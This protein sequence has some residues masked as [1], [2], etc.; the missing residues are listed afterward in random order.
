[1]A[2]TGHK[3]EK[4]FLNY[5]GKDFNDLSK[6]MLEYWKEQKEKQDTG[7]IQNTKTAN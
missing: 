2:I 5:I 3:T 1:M 4:E 7:T 6:Q